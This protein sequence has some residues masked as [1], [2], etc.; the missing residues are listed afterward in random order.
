MP[1]I[2]HYPKNK[3]LIFPLFLLFLVSCGED[4]A[5]KKEKYYFAD[6]DREWLPADT[7][8]DVFLMR[9][10]NG[11]TLSLAKNSEDYYFNKSWSSFLGVNTHMSLTEYSYIS[12]HSPFGQDLHISLTAGW[13]PYGD[14]LYVSLN[15]IAFSWDF[16]YKTIHR[17]EAGDQ[18][19]SKL[20]TDDGYEEQEKIWST[21]EFLDTLRTSER[22]YHDVM[23]FTLLDFMNSGQIN[24]FRVR[25]IY[26]AK[27]RGLIRYDLQNGMW[28]ERVSE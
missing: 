13:P 25:H 27:N 26:L 24:P 17:L 11:I 18:Y 4:H 9:D 1:S 20:M 28:Y 23:H 14:E 16:G 8:A 2:I 21:V 6:E 7:L 22:V 19:L 15:G 5:L 12:Y 10:N 3:L